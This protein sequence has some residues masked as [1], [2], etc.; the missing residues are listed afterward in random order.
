[1]FIFFACLYALFLRVQRKRTSSVLCG[2]RKDS[3]PLGLR[4]PCATR[5]ESALRKVVK[6]IPPCGVL[7]RIAYPLIT[8]L[9]GC[10]KWQNIKHVSFSFFTGSAEVASK[11]RFLGMMFILAGQSSL[12]AEI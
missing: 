10:V 11:F 1:M 8:L 3:R 2:E 12:F 6:F 5:K 4:L 9:L 7:R